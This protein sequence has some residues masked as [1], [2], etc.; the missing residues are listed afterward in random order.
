MASPWAVLA[1]TAA[2]ALAQVRPG[3]MLPPL[4]GGPGS[5]NWFAAIAAASGGGKGAAIAAARHLVPA[6]T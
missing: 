6:T 2:R 3:I 5:L 4:I 1:Y